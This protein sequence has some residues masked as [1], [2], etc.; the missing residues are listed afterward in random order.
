M[1][2]AD[3]DWP[4]PQI[5]MDVD[6][7]LQRFFDNIKEEKEEKKREKRRAA[8]RRKAERTAANR[9]SSET[10]VASDTGQSNDGEMQSENFTCPLP[11]EHT[12]STTPKPKPPKNRAIMPSGNAQRSM[13]MIIIQTAKKGT[14]APCS[15]RVATMAPCVRFPKLA[16]RKCTT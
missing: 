2:D 10:T 11:E 16:K 8:R 14:R 15:P 1:G 5:P 7:Q 3:A 9:A 4:T 6:S 13:R 12:T